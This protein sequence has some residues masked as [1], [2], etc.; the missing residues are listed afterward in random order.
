MPN[1][2]IYTFTEEE[3]VLWV[4]AHTSVKYQKLS[5]HS[6]VQSTAV[7]RVLEM[8]TNLFNKE[9]KKIKIEFKVDLKL[10][11]S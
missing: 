4:S 3:Q 2:I 5:E 11:Y 6:L 1:I 7:F 10:R 8:E 9:I